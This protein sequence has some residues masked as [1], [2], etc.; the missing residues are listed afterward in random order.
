MGGRYGRVPNLHQAA[1]Q[2]SELL[3]RLGS[4]ALEERLR[5]RVTVATRMEDVLTN[6]SWRFGSNDPGVMR[7]VTIN[8]Y[9]RFRPGLALPSSDRRLRNNESGHGMGD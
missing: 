7:S 2:T 5:R 8:L 4:A 6:T 9:L 3:R 1:D